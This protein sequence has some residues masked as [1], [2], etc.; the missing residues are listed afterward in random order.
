MKD[1]DNLRW[2]TRKPC[3]RECCDCER[4]YHARETHIRA[5]ITPMLSWL[6]KKI[7]ASFCTSGDNSEKGNEKIQLSKACEHHRQ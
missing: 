5:H 4:R 7:P 3:M 2:V 1:S 6:C